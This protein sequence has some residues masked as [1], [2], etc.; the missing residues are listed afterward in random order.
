MKSSNEI[1]LILADELSA[2]INNIDNKIDTTGY[3]N[4]KLGDTSFLLAGLLHMLLKENDLERMVWIDDSLITDIKTYNNEVFIS[5]IMIWGKENT[6][7]Q[8]VDPFSFSIK[9][10]KSPSDS[11]KY[12]FLFKD[13]DIKEISYEHFREDRDYFNNQNRRWNYEINKLLD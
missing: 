11:I 13:S 1:A 7:E 8:W 6:T 10:N 9:L 12:C 2:Y 4:D 3:F 5:G